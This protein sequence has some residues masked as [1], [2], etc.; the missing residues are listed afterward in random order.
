MVL[1]HALWRNPRRRNVFCCAIIIK[2]QRRYLNFER[3]YILTG[4]ETPRRGQ[5]K[6]TTSVSR[7]K[8]LPKTH[9][10]SFNPA[11]ST[12]TTF[13]TSKR[14]SPS[15]ARELSS[16]PPMS[17][18]ATPTVFFTAS[19]R[20][21]TAGAAHPPS[22]PLYAQ[23]DDDTVGISTQST[24]AGDP[25]LSVYDELT[26]FDDDYDTVTPPNNPRVTVYKTS[27]NLPAYVN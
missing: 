8:G 18:A 20:L 17:T 24:T 6:K 4:E 7:S 14:S 12:D 27:Q 21:T 16:N 3:R 26:G 23:P 25:S 13:S 15:T 19:A 2:A 1:L 10:T 11:F 5:T 9:N 22:S